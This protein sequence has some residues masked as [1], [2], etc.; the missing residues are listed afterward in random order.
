MDLFWKNAPQELLEEKTSFNQPRDKIGDLLVK[1]NMI[2]TDQLLKALKVQKETGK[3]L[4]KVLVEMGYITEEDVSKAL[5]QQ[6]DIMTIDLDAAD[7]QQDLIDEI[8]IKVMKQYRMIPLEKQELTAKKMVTIAVT[9]P[10]DPQQLETLQKTIGYTV[11]PV[12]AQDKTFNQLFHQL[13]YRESQ[14]TRKAKFTDLAKGFLNNILSDALK[15]KA[16]D[17]LLEP[18][19]KDL[20]VSFRIGG[21][22]FKVPSPPFE[23]S[24]YIIKRI[25]KLA[26]LEDTDALGTFGVRGQF[27]VKTKIKS[28][29]FLV[30]NFLVPSGENI[31]I[32]IIDEAIYSQK[33]NKLILDPASLKIVHTIL[34][35]K[36]GI[37]FLSGPIGSGKIMT[38]YAL[39]RAIEESARKI[40][41][42]EHPLITNIHSVLQKEVNVQEGETFYQKF[43]LALKEYPDILAIGEL[44]DENLARQIFKAAQDIL[45]IVVADFLR[46]S[47]LLLYLHG[48]GIKKSSLGQINAIVSQRLLP[49]ICNQCRDEMELEEDDLNFLGIQPTDQ[50]KGFR[51]KGCQLCGGTG[52]SGF[53]PLIEV[54]PFDDQIRQ[55]I[56]TSDSFAWLDKYPSPSNAR[57]I[58]KL[59]AD[60]LIKGWINID[61]ARALELKED[62]PPVDM[63]SFPESYKDKGN[64]DKI[65]II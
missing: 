13:T 49:S 58:K 15:R 47:E 16:S 41:S 39:L 52:Y 3:K 33:L 50:V 43:L 59:V 10:I 8:G 28:Y 42:I 26:K 14:A 27:Q 31:N 23:L 32:K 48:L 2:T 9:S 5:S 65:S 51:G 21:R 11:Y 61:D 19:E 24:S 64:T 29:D 57:S 44:D 7:I 35:A 63:S 4:G 18:E 54:L 12:L 30:N 36:K 20:S 60:I 56:G 46:P 53:I 34:Q 1:K 38:L 17:I 37:I 22:L 6:F 45:L 40:T 55:T 62:S 25:K